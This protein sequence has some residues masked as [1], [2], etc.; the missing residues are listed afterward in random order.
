M[1]EFNSDIA[2]LRQLT[3]EALGRRRQTK[4]FQLRRMKTMRQRLNVFTEI[5][6][7]LTG[8]LEILVHID[9]RARGLMIA[10]F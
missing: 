4:V 10:A 5:S 6:Y 8:K 2:L 7:A 3:A 1:L 9:R